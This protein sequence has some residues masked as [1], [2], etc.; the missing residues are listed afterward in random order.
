[1]SRAHLT[2]PLLLIAVKES[3]PAEETRT[4]PVLGFLARN[5]D[6]IKKHH[7][8]SFAQLAA[9]AGVSLS[10]VKY[11]VSCRANPGIADLLRLADAVGLTLSELV[12]EECDPAKLP[13][14]PVVVRRYRNP[15]AI[16]QQIGPR[17]GGFRIRNGFSRRAF[18]SHA[19][20]SKG[21][22]HYIETC[23]IEPSTIMTERLAKAFEMSFAAFV[24]ANESPVISLVK[25]Q[26]VAS[27]GAATN[28][29]LFSD[30]HAGGVTH[31][32]ECR[33][34]G[35]QRLVVE[36][37]PPGSIVAVYVVEGTVRLTLDT[38]HHLLELGDAVQLLADQR[39]LIA[40]STTQ[41]ARFL[42][43]LR[44]T[45]KRSEKSEPASE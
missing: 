24:E 40:S 8:W 4:S 20:I 32:S 36:R 42:F 7:G 34:E 43:V 9:R 18:V 22:L 30:P 16:A 14:D 25:R 12:E 15:E 21:M 6:L 35:R 3:E 33:V 19:G 38:E 10:L 13:R 2:T 44:E 41:P 11:A 27:T 5:L 28:R 29:A 31:F 45:G 39:M 1:M 17:V 23:A 37:H 26:H